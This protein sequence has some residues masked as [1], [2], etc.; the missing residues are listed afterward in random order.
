MSTRGSKSSQVF[1]RICAGEIADGADTSREVCGGTNSPGDVGTPFDTEE[2]GVVVT[3]TPTWCPHPTIVNAAAN[4]PPAM[5]TGLRP[6]NDIPMST[7]YPPIPE[8]NARA[9]PPFSSEGRFP[10]LDREVWRFNCRTRSFSA[11]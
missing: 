9:R 5:T 1:R 3:G 2:F 4:T 11:H 7:A 8:G 6:R 10:R